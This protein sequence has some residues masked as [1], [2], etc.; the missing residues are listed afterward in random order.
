MANILCVA[1]HP[2][3]EV[4]GCGG[5]LSRHVAAGDSVRVLFVAD[6]VGAR[7]SDSTDIDYKALESRLSMAKKALECLGVNSFN[8][9]NFPDNQLDIMPLLKITQAIEGVIGEYQPDIIYTHYLYDLNIDHQITA[10]AVLTACRPVPNFC[11]KR[12][13]SFEVASS[14]EWGL[15]GN[16]FMPNVFTDISDTWERKKLALHAYNTEMREAPHA[17]SFEALQA[18]AVS[19]GASVGMNKAEAFILLRDLQRADKK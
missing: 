8:S 7:S 5:T 15:P 3:D 19:R 1:A 14:T 17:R 18:L 11:V 12:L 10:R 13:L 6:G 4:L 16:A 9:L 2:D